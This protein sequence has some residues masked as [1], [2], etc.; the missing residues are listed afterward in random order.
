MRELN[1]DVEGQ[2][3]TVLVRPSGPALAGAQQAETHLALSIT[4]IG[5][6]A[7]WF[8]SSLKALASGL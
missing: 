6:Y 1:V 7:C 8:E 2:R 4:L 3:A 5:P